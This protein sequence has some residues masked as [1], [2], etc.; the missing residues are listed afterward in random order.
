MK[1]GHRPEGLVCDDLSFYPPPKWGILV[2]RYHSSLAH[3]TTTCDISARRLH[4]EASTCV[5]VYDATYLNPTDGGHRYAAVIAAW[6]TLA[7]QTYH[8]YVQRL[9]LWPEGR[10]CDVRA[11]L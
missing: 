7:Q 1:I 10:D 9:D 6:H 3:A 11:R 5:L 8:Y 2:G 4:V